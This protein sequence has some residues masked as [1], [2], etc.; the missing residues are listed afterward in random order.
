MAVD[1]GIQMVFIFN[2]GIQMKR[3]ELTKT[4]MM[5]SNWQNPLVSTVYKNIFPRSKGQKVKLAAGRGLQASHSVF[6][7]V[8]L[9]VCAVLVGAGDWTGNNC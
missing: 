7:R 5:I 4:F 3:K 6:I 9:L 1:I 8:I 2:I